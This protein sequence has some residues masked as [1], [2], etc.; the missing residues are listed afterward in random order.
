[1][2][3]KVEIVTQERVLFEGEA[4]MVIVPGSEGEMGILPHH[5]PLL[6]TLS[7]G[8]LRL[9]TAEGELY[10]AISGGVVEV[11]PDRV[12]VLADIAERSDEIDIARAQAAR[13]RAAEALREGAVDPRTAAALDAALKRAEVRLKV[14]RQRSGQIRPGSVSI[15]SEE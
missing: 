2:S 13:D 4:D 15:R 14:A 3:I 5:T 8:Q 11:Q 10:F 7:L 9:K 6:S 1:M 12:T